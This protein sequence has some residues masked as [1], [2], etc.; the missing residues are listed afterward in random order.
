[1]IN[2][3]EL[4]KII[5]VVNLVFMFLLLFFGLIFLSEK[6]IIEC[7][8]SAIFVF[9]SAHFYFSRFNRGKAFFEEN[10]EVSIWHL[11]GLLI[12]PI[13]FFTFGLKAELLGKT[14]AVCILAYNL[15]AGMIGGE[16]HYLK[17]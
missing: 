9:S 7:S 15:I 6:K 1:M 13:I 2:I 4:R 17:S 5:T 11:F 14:N 8:L 12:L 16:L 10:L 3:R